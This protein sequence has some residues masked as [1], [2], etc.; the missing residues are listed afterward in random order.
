MYYLEILIS[1][2]QNIMENHTAIESTK[3]SK[4]ALAPTSFLSLPAEVRQQIL[5]H[6]HF[7]LINISTIKEARDYSDEQFINGT[8]F[9]NLFDEQSKWV[10]TLLQVDPRLIE[11]VNIVEKEWRKWDGIADREAWIALGWWGMRI[12]RWRDEEASRKT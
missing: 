8:I 9:D 2:I 4:P 5:L 10:R 6:T 12:Q 3:I 1:S 7:V 11:E